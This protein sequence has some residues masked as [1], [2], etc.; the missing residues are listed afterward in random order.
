[1]SALGKGYHIS[2]CLYSLPAQVALSDL[3][4]LDGLADGCFI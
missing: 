4:K 2:Y 3:S 1:M